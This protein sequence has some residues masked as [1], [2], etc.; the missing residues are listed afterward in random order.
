M[1]LKFIRFCWGQE[2]LP[3]SNYEYQERHIRFLIKPS[4]YEDSQDR[5]LPRADTCF[6]NFELPNYSSLEVLRERI[7][8]AINIDSDSMNADIVQDRV[9][10]I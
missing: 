10:N 6:F 4:L 1:L 9:N 8:L 2:R 3:N 7:L 5:L